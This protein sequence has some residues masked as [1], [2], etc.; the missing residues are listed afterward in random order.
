MQPIYPGE[1]RPPPRVGNIG[2]LTR[3]SNK[4]V[5]LGNSNSDILAH[6]QV[7]FIIFVVNYSKLKIDI[8]T[9]M[10]CMDFTSFLVDVFSIVLTLI[11]LIHNLI[12]FFLFL[13][14][15]VLINIAL[16]TV[17]FLSLCFSFSVD[18]LF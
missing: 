11:F 9:I 13:S 8:M 12:W 17:L 3:I 6:L 4:L 7:Y 1:D 10:N 5:Q 14:S 15:F 2:H 18:P 16:C